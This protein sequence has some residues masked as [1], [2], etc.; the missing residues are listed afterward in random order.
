MSE[1]QVFSVTLD[2]ERAAQL[3]RL[4]ARL[5]STR[6]AAA[7]S[8]LSRALDVAE[9]EAFNLLQVLD[10]IQGHMSAPCSAVARPPR[11]TPWRLKTYRRGRCG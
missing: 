9:P 8:L 10:D 3:S 2:V 6:E 4:A 11:A 1:L 7:R 5:E